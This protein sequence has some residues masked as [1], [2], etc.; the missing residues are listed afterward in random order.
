MLTVN[1]SYNHL[2]SCKGLNHYGWML[3]VSWIG[4]TQG[5]NHR[6]PC[7]RINSY[8]WMHLVSW[9]SLIQGCNYWVP[10]KSVNP[11]SQMDFVSWPYMTQGRI[12]RA[13]CEA[14]IHINEYVKLTLSC[15]RSANIRHFVKV[16][17]PYSWIQ[18]ISLH[19]ATII[20]RLLKSS[21][22]TVESI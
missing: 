10:C 14:F 20:G 13:P 9:L 22:P 16:Q 21:I 3:L 4:L 17:K 2:P 19:R 6:A 8:S 18:F 12:H 15:H 5:S 7:E 11:Y 1:W